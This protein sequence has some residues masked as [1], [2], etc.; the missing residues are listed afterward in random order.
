MQLFRRDHHQKIA[1][2]L[3]LLNSTLLEKNSCYFGGGTAIA[4]RYGEFR[5]SVDIDFL[6]SDQPAYR[7]LRSEIRQAGLQI[8]MLNGAL[9][10][11][12]IEEVKV[13]RYGIR[14]FLKLTNQR[15]KFEIVHEGRIELCKASENDEICGVKC[16]SPLDMLCSKLLANSDRWPDR[17]V[18][19]RDI[20]DIAMMSAPLSLLKDAVLKA[21]DAYGR[22][23]LEDLEK[24]IET[25]FSNKDWFI[26]CMKALS[27][28]IPEAVLWNK[29]RSLKRVLK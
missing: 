25:M 20:I 28:D 18:F 19:N 1:H 10:H 7:Y 14:T 11:I 12:Q 13:D 3:S 4:L 2:I 5:E 9:E 29:I 17:S 16:L 21:E 8:I 6:V 22:T 23:V 26:R 27:I 15:I 24:S